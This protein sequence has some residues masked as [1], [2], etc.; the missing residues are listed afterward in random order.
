MGNENGKEMRKGD[1]CTYK[2]RA[3]QTR[4]RLAGGR[5]PVQYRVPNGGGAPANLGRT[6]RG[7]GVFDGLICFLCWSGQKASFPV[8]EALGGPGK[9]TGDRV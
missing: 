6:V 4:E 2:T 7:V 3:C 5:V 9:G 8:F 1:L